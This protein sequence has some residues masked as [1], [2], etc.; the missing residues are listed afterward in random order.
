MTSRYMSS[1]S[2]PFVPPGRSSCVDL[3]DAADG[4]GEPVD[5][6]GRVVE[7]EARAVRGGDAELAPQRL[8]AV[9]AGAD[10]DAVE[11]EELGDVVQVNRRA[12]G[13][14]VEAHD[15]GAAV[16]GRAVQRHARDLAELLE[17]VA[18]EGVLVRRDRVEPDGLEV[19]DG[20]AETDGLGH[21]RGAGLELRGQLAPGRLVLADV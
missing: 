17:R 3:P 4:R 12:A 8:A 18:G 19:V 14:E 11:V 15:A 1:N 2:L 16:G 9:V 21:R 6:L 13:V 7:V 5:V 20:G 10:A